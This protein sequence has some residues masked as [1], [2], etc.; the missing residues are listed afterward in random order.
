MYKARTGSDLPLCKI[1]FTVKS[2]INVL[3]HVHCQT[4]R[5][6]KTM[7]FIEI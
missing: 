4:S 5:K 2:K 1:P 3:F 6:S 7:D